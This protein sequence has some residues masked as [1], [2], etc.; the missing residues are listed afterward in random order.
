MSV[1]YAEP[2]RLPLGADA[3]QVLVGALPWLTLPAPLAAADGPVLSAAQQTAALGALHGAGVLRGPRVE[4]DLHPSVRA[5]LLVHA[6]PDVLVDTVVQRGAARTTA[7]HAVAGPLGAGLVRQ[8]SE[9]PEGRATGGVELSGFLL[10][11]LAAEVVRAL[12][13]PP[14]L[15]GRRPARLD[16][17][18]AL[19]VV[20]AS[21]E[22]RPCLAAMLTGSAVPAALVA[23]AGRPQAVAHLTLRSTRTTRSLVLLETADDGWWDVHTTDGEV[24]LRP[25]D[26]DV[27]LTLLAAGLTACLT[28]PVAPGAAGPLTAPTGAGGPR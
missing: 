15:P 22:D 1:A 9:T 21:A 12:G 14:P 8:T 18:A 6:R 7:R 16:P 25:V 24:V 17:A 2:R 13:D 26:R 10:D 19:A 27:L 23:I 3:W 20:R 5:G 11:D 4:A 28:G